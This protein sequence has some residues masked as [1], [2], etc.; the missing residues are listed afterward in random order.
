MQAFYANARSLKNKLPELHK[1]IIK[2]NFEIF[3]FSE[4]WLDDSISDSML[5]NKC[6]F[7]VFRKDRPTRG[8]GVCMLIKNKIECTE[9]ALPSMFSG[10]ELIAVDII[11]SKSCKRR[12]V[13]F[14]RP[15]NYD[16]NYL[17]LLCECIT[18]LSECPHPI[19][20]I[21]DLNFPGIVW[22]SHEAKN[23]NFDCVFLDCCL[24]NSLSQLVRQST[25][26]VSNNT[27]D[28]IL[29]NSP[30]EIIDSCVVLPFSTS[31]HNALNFSIRTEVPNF[32]ENLNFSRNFRKMNDSKIS[33]ELSKLDWPSFFADVKT[34]INSAYAKLDHLIETLVAMHVPLRS[35]FS[36][37]ARYPKVIRKLCNQKL[38]AWKKLSNINRVSP[39][40]SKFADRFK[41]LANEYKAAVDKF[42]KDAEIELIQANDISRLYSYVNSQLGS[43]S[44]I[45]TLI[46]PNG[47]L[48]TSDRE[49]SD[50]LNEQFCSVF[51]RD[52]ATAPNM[53]NRM[54]DDELIDFDFSVKDVLD[55][56]KTLS[57]SYAICPDNLPTVFFKRF[58]TALAVPLHLLFRLSL[59]Q[60]VVPNIW[61]SA[62][63][64]PIPKKGSSSKPA[65]YRPVSLTCTACRIF[66]TLIRNRMLDFLLYHGLLSKDQHGFMRK[67]S[68]STQML[69]CLYD[70]SYSVETRRFV[71]IIYLDLAKAFD[72]VS[73]AKLLAKLEHVGIRGRMLEWIS[74]FL[75]GRTQ[76][77]SVNGTLS[78]TT[79]VISGVP[80]GSVL[81]P[82]LFLVFIND[83]T[84]DL[85]TGV[86]IKLF[87]DDCKLYVAFTREQDCSILSLALDSVFAWLATWQLKLSIEK[88]AVLHIGKNNPRFDYML[89]KVLLTKCSS[90]K[91]L[92]VLVDEK[93][94]FKLHI[95]GIIAK[96]YSRLNLIFRCFKTKDPFILKWAYCVYVRPLLEYG[97]SIWSPHYINQINNIERVQ[98]YFSRRALGHK[99]S[100][101]NRPS[102]QQRLAFLKLESLES[103]RLKADI[104]FLYKIVNKS[105]RCSLL[106]KITFKSNSNR[107]HKYRYTVMTRNDNYRFATTETCK[108]FFLNRTINVWNNLPVDF[109]NFEN[110]EPKLKTEELNFVMKRKVKFELDISRYL[111]CNL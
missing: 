7:K 37:K 17:N 57:D 6:K 86:R 63:V 108:N 95:K 84:A 100:D 12:I 5:L 92:G 21:G 69:E 91:D 31:D 96:A 77:V 14:Y 33:D 88:C 64:A 55:V 79:P 18:Y 94:S 20:F 15:P 10:I 8:G 16:A 105:V 59:D 72:S 39:L 87:A 107:G 81:G 67:R 101:S 30:V 102:Y 32:S 11:V 89:D 3:C 54:T 41:R 23:E 26:V 99:L 42:E 43:A 38:V 27:L 53:S 29:T 45:P 51:T 66:E 60:G 65:D 35:N 62:F 22:A 61:K 46:S 1:L 24:Q 25:H 44:N 28:V 110:I 74:Q 2:P 4:T 103:R 97:S 58:Q 80:Q 109:F 104:L 13:C 70:W 83:V 106:D 40:Y 19:F 56:M 73:H 93:L 47:K 98:A 76:A 78:D 85:P 36:F 90:Y 82:L 111:R 34:D 50:A 48:C 52:D 9:V 75:R 68:T 49:K 71:D